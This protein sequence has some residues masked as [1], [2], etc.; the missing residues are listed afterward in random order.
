MLLFF[1]SSRS[2][3]PFLF[4]IGCLNILLGLL[5]REGVN[6]KR[7]LR[8]KRGGKGIIGNNVDTR[9]QFV[10]ASP[11]FV[12]NVFSGNGTED[13]KEIDFAT[14]KSTDTA[15]L[16]SPLAVVPRRPL[17]RFPF[18]PRPLPLARAQRLLAQQLLR[19]LALLELLA[20]EQLKLRVARETI[21]IPDTPRPETPPPIHASSRRYSSTA[22][23]P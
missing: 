7:S 1:T 6:T 21:Q 10:N 12:K 8:A 22:R 2:S 20:R 3:P 23:L 19:L 4:S 13:A 5:F 9:P 17:A 16:L 15:M 18:A 14:W 11:Q